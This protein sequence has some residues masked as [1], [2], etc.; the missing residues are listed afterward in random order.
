M[1]ALMDMLKPKE[2]EP[3]TMSDEVTEVDQLSA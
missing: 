2:E 3:A 1:D